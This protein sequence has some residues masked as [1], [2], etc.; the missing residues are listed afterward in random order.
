MGKRSSP[1]V[2]VHGTGLRLVRER[3]GLTAADLADAA[4]CDRTTIAN[5]E[6]GHRFPSVELWARI[7]QV[8][9]INQIDLRLPLPGSAPWDRYMQAVQER[10][11]VAA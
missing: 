8:L 6:R 7:C 2:P 5:I 10:E 4:Q 3:H 11:A 9:D 1:V